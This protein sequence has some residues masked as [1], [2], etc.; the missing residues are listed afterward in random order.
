MMKRASFLIDMGQDQEAHDL[1]EAVNRY[2]HL[3]GWSRKRMFL[4]GVARVISDNEDNPE[5]IMQIA[6][7]LEKRR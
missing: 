2:T 1:M 7:Y 3:L 5:L 4:M 6:D